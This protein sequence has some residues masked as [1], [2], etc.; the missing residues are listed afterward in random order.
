VESRPQS[1]PESPPR[2]SDLDPAE[3]WTLAAARPVGRLAWTGA[4]GPT[5]IPVNFV[6]TGAEVLVRTTAYSEAARECDDSPV[7][8]E[9]DDVD[10]AT[11]SGWSV[12]MRGRGHLECGPSGDAEP[13]VWPPGPRALRLR[14]EVTEVTGRRITTSA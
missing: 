14:I 9:V 4:H 6:V 8:F 1:Q 2:V 12:L 5:V 7:A 3:C 10:A 13:D 11:R